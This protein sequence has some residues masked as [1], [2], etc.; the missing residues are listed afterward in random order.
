M[1]SPGNTKQAESESLVKR[2]MSSYGSPGHTEHEDDRPD[3]RQQS[4]DDV[5]C[6]PSLSSFKFRLKT[7]LFRSVYID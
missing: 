1:M 6:A 2:M 3:S 5:R 7:Y 4:A